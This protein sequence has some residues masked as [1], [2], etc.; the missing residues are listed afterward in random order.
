[1]DRSQLFAPGHDA[2]LLAKVFDAGADAVLL[3]LEDAVAISEKPATRDLVVAAFSQPRHGK[4][5][6]R[7]NA[8]TTE[9][10][11]ADLLAIA[12][13]G[14]S[15]PSS[16]PATHGRSKRACAACCQARM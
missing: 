10:C 15:I 14:I 11:F 16:A 3:D 6:V 12:R 1:M 8:Y 4:L 5:Y 9:W 7:V 13:P 2:K